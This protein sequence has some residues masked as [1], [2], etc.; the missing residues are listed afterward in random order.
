VEADG[1]AHKS[2]KAPTPTEPVIPYNTSLVIPIVGIDAVGCHLTEKNVFRPEIVSKLLG[3]PIGEVISAESIAF[4]ITH[5]QG[6]IKGSPDRARIVPFI[7]KVDLDEGLSKGRSL[8]NKILTMRH[9]RIKQVVLGQAQ[10][11]EPL[12]EVISREVG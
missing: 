7:N 12:V 9:P 1:E 8:A 10:L 5:H 4:L 3:V 6:I 11:P 2:L